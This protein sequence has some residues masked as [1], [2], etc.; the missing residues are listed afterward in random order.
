M[1]LEAIPIQVQTPPKDDDPDS[2]PEF[3]SE[4]MDSSEVPND[5]DIEQRENHEASDGDAE[6]DGSEEEIVVEP[7]DNELDNED[8][9]GAESP[10]SSASD[11]DAEPEVPKSRT[12]LV[13]RFRFMSSPNVRDISVV[14]SPP[15]K[16]T[17][18]GLRKLGD[19]EGIRARLDRR[20]GSD[21]LLKVLTCIEIRLI[22]KNLHRVIYKRPGTSHEVKK[23]L[24]DFTGFHFADIV[25]PSFL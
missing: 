15:Q 22:L 11:S 18:P 23:N 14:I 20:L 25:Y 6:G 5:R 16:E 13:F 21:E 3:S 2:V 12:F 8:E 9:Y 1:D 17:A 19:V 7:K 4:P 24:R 10:F